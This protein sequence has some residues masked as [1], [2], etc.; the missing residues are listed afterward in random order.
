MIFLDSTC[1]LTLT[2]LHRVR[3]IENVSLCIWAKSSC[4]FEWDQAVME[5]NTMA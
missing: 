3:Q 4:P 5:V 1:Q 2:L